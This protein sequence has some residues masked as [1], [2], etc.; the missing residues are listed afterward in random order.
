MT[1]LETSFLIDLLRGDDAATEIAESIDE[2]GKRATVTPVAASE[3]W[4]GANLGT[5][6]ERDSAAELLESLTWLEFSR[7]S[8][9]RAGEI[10]A[11]LKRDGEVIGF[12]DCMIAAIAITH[13]ETLV[14][15][16]SDFER[17]DDI[18]TVTYK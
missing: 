11:E 1:C 8:A 6:A 4:V 16:D 15:R 2:R 5:A 12:T 10:Q 18:E 13:G 9:E 14:T 7:K 17:I 3:M